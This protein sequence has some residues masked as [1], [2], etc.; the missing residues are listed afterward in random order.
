MNK[1]ISKSARLRKYRDVYEILVNGKIKKKVTFN[2]NDSIKI[3]S[4]IRSP[5]NNER[6]HEKE[7]RPLNSY[8]KFIQTESMK[9]KYKK[10]S[11]KSR[12]RSIATDW[13][14]HK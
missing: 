1:K 2:N 9:T 4:P 7:K 10:I 8:Q 14:K 13:K 6:S 5:P 11:P 3:Y 12:M